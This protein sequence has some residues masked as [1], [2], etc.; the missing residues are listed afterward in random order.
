MYSNIQNIVVNYRQR[1]VGVLTKVLAS[2][3]SRS[4]SYSLRLLQVMRYS[5]FSKSAKRLRPILVYAVGKALHAPL[6]S[7]DFPAAAVELMHTYS[8]IHDDLPALDNDDY[9]RDQLAC[10]KAFD[11]ASA[12]L[13]GNAMQLLACEILTQSSHP[14]TEGQKLKCLQILTAESGMNGMLQGQMMDI[15]L[16][17]K[18][19][20]STLESVYRLKTGCLLK[21]ALLLGAVSANCQDTFILNRLDQFAQT[22][23][24]AFQIQD[25]ILDFGTTF[26]EKAAL[27][28]PALLGMEKSK[29]RVK[30]LYESAVEILKELP[31]DIK[32]LKAIAKLMVFRSY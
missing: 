25:D 2:Q 28:F 8:L 27:T 22:I 31:F 3:N 15:K 12:I 7:L 5:L 14:L 32:L 16:T 17:D 24:L 4:R 20:L 10:H 21:A 6:V 26:Q 19:D 23:G 11:E 29:N 18:C 9:R 30:R 1:I 13:A